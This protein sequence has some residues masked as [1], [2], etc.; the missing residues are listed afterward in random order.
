MCAGLAERLETSPSPYYL[1][2]GTVDAAKDAVF[3]GIL[4]AGVPLF[5]DDLAAGEFMGVSPS[6]FA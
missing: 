3:D 4:K 1:K 5:W 2:R 6:A